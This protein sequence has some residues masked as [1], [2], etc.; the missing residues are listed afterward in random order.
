V[1]AWPAEPDIK[2]VARDLGRVLKASQ[3]G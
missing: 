2:G 1:L 3:I